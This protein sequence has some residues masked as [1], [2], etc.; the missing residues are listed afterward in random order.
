MDDIAEEFGIGRPFRSKGKG[1]NEKPPHSAKRNQAQCGA[2]HRPFVVVCAH[3]LAEP[4]QFIALFRLTSMLFNARAGF[5]PLTSP[6]F[7][8]H[9]LGS[10]VNSLGGGAGKGSPSTPLQ[11]K[12]PRRP[13]P[14][15]CCA[16]CIPARSAASWD[17][18]VAG[19]AA[20]AGWLCGL[21]PEA[22]PVSGPESV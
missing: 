22:T 12:P 8:A 9:V 21:A 19:A 10:L 16:P 4:S 18:P 5:G 2:S 14:C 6:R 20:G 17:W 3:R 13:P 7:S 15:G 1:S 11:V